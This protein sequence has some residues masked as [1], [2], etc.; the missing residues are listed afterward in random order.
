MS[1]GHTA[2]AG[3]T[4]AAVLARAQA[5]VVRASRTKA[6]VERLQSRYQDRADSARY[7][8]EAMSTLKVDSSTTDA[9][10]EVSTLSNAMAE[11]VAGIVSASD[12][13]TTAAEELDRA[14]QAEHGRM[15]EANRTHEVPMADGAFIKR[16]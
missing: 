14:T 3:V 1:A 6:A 2:G 10:M 7:L 9:Y 4:Y 8:S 12:A 15:A 5:Y 11:N 13:L 16:Q